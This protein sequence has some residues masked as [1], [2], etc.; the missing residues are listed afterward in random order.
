MRY[1]AEAHDNF[2]IE[3]IHLAKSYG[4]K[5]AVRDVNL[6]ITSGEFFGILGPNGAGKTSTLAMLCG[7]S[8]PTGGQVRIA[9]ASAH[10]RT[11]RL[12]HL[13]GLVPQDMAFYPSLSAWENLRFFGAIYGLHGGRLRERCL[14]VL[15][16]T[17]LM[18]REHEP[19]AC[20]SGGMKRRLNIAIGLLHQPQI[21][22]LDEPTVGV[23]AQSRYAIFSALQRLNQ[24][25]GVTVIYCTHY[26][27]EAERLCERVAIM[28]QG[29]VIA[30]GAPQA[31]ARSYVQTVVEVEFATP[32]PDQL[33][34]MLKQF[35]ELQ[36]VSTSTEC[37]ILETPQPEDL[38]PRLYEVS[39]QS[40][41]KIRRLRLLEPGLEA[42]FLKLTGR[43][44]RD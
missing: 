25:Q 10:V 23:D 34:T 3:A 40:G 33:L 36:Q 31:L 35:A 16:I 26:M 17:G 12:R 41:N 5:Q 42:V 27:E 37:V 14:E 4:A 6:A 15:N 30:L 2:S 19:V 11:T 1:G 21:L 38:L 9:G 44:L 22:I 28:D 43:Q 18:G 13:L 8:K 29:Q 24:D 20:F 32:V 39:R 7:L